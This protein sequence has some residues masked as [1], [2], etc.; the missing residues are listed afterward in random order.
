MRIRTL[1]MK[2]FLDLARNR[3]ALLPVVLVTV[4]SLVLPFGIAI[5]VPALTGRGLGDDADLVK[6]SAVAGV[7]RPA[8][9]TMR[10]CSCSC[11]SSS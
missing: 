3:A 2:E 9:P 10:A 11:S 4:M 1:I 7:D 6:V 8:C 5:L